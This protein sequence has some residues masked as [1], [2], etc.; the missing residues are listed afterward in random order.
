MAGT[1]MTVLGP[2]DADRLGRVL[3]H[4]HLRISYPGDWL[5][6]LTKWDRARCVE[7]AVERMQGLA[8]HGV[9]TV[10]DPCPIDLGRDPELMAEVAERSG[11]QIVCSTGFYHEADAIGIPYYWR[12][13]S[14]EEVAE[15]YRSEIHDGIGATGI[16]PGVI[17]IASG[18]PPGE[19]D[20]KVIAAAAIAARSSGLGVISHCEHSRG[21]DTQQDILEAGG[22][23]LG[24]CLIGH[25]DEETDV[26]NLRRIA[27][28]GSFVGIDRVGYRLLAP[29]AQRADHVAALVRDGYADRVCLSQDHMCCLVSPRFPYRIP[30]GA[31]ETFRQVEPMVREDMYERP[32]T[33]LFTD[34]LPML[35]ERGVDG[36]TVERILVDN[37]R[38][39]LA[40]AG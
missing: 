35:A 40:G 38:R 39:L 17:K 9:R 14:A 22:V 21:G 36:A 5:D 1:V 4:E 29:E 26:A 2:V 25:Q 11:M 23:D 24:R 13:R 16:R 12:V 37:P 27:D 28:R 19:Q 20:R 6:P 32:H 7:L 3:V 33:Y 8:E 18:A 15:F 34:F 30:E 10:V 31:E